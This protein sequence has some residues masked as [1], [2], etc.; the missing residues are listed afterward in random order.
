MALQ[1]VA[2]DLKTGGVLADLP[3][4]V[5]QWPLRRTLC[6]YETATGDLFLDGAPPNWQAAIREG[7]SVLVCYDDDDPTRAPQWGGIVTETTP[8]S[9]DDAVAVSMCTA[10][11]YLD[12]RFVG[13]YSVT[14]TAQSLIA[15]DLVTLFAADAAGVPF[16]VELVGTYNG[17][18]RDREYLDA[19]NATVYARLSELAA[20]DGGVE[21]TVEW[22]WGADQTTLVPVV[23][24]GARIGTSPPAGLQPA[25]S[26]E[27]PGAVIEASQTRSYA[28]GKG[29][30]VVR[31]YS[32]GQG[33]AAPTS[34]NIAALDDEGRPTFEFRYQPSTSITD[35]A[36]LAD[37]ARSA[38]ALL[39][40]GM[41]ALT[42]RAALL[43]STRHGGTWRIGDDVGY[44]IGGTAVDPDTG[45]TFEIVKAF[46]GGLSGAD[47]AVAY[48]L[49]EDPD[50]GST[51]TPIL[52]QTVIPGGSS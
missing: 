4:F 47:R 18:N 44:R 3:T 13:D 34:G 11:G 40:P 14:N 39:G 27:L 33:D 15:S 46:P 9:T 30:N 12:R 45:D 23:L 6:K 52:A 20:V 2:A 26:F 37:Y 36:T 38:V 7:G 5:P 51:I 21:F 24:L 1:W 49:A 42:L 32:S 28:D 29:A 17:P 41:R 8:T 43:D 31:A 48:E 10:E 35:T 22:R 50:Q 19:D 25:A 16:V